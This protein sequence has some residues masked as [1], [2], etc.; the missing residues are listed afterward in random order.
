MA[1]SAITTGNQRQSLALTAADTIK[2]RLTSRH[3]DGLAW[4]IIRSIHFLAILLNYFYFRSI[5]GHTLTGLDSGAML[6]AGGIDSGT[7]DFTLDIWLLKNEN[8]TLAGSLQKVKRDYF[9]F[10][11]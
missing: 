7:N 2:S 11:L 3:L 1:I 4:L 9:E 8:W 6:M 5:K 10:F